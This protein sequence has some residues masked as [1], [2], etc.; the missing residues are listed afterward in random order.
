MALLV[1][2]G[3]STVVLPSSMMESLGF[4]PEAL[5]NRVAQ[6][7]NGKVAAKVGVLSSVI[8]GAVRAD[9]VRV[10]FVPDGGLSANNLLG[11]SFLERFRV[12]IDD[13]GQRLIL[14]AE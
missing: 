7:A 3:A 2:T 4:Q 14:V 9:E 8:V 1:D 11:M 5:E 6:T 12:T 13:A 10:T